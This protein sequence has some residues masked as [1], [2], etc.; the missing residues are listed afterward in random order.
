MHTAST[1]DHSR[2]YSVR[3]SAGSRLTVV[4]V[5]VPIDWSYRLALPTPVV[6]TDSRYAVAPIASL[7]LN[8]VVW[9]SSADPGIGLVKTAA[10][11]S[12]VTIRVMV[13]PSAAKVTV[14]AAVADPTGA[15]RTV[16]SCVAPSPT[17]AK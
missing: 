15:K 7:Q 3:P 10:L 17:R 12:P 4:D 8:V 16:T 5:F 2:T 9:L 1:K 14:A 13:S 6:P 11:V